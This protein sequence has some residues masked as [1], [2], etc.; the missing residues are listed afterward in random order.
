MAFAEAS[1]LGDCVTLLYPLTGMVN[2]AR[3]RWEGCILLCVSA[4]WVLLIPDAYSAPA[5]M[6]NAPS[7][8][9]FIEGGE[10][11]MGSQELTATTCP[12]L[13]GMRLVADAQP[14]HKVVISPFWIDETEV[15]NKAFGQFVQS[16]GYVTVAER[17]PSESELPGVPPEMRVPGG[18][19]FSPPKQGTVIDD[20]YQW[21]KF[22]KGADWR[23][24]EGPSSSLTGR[25][26]HPV[27]QVTYADAEAYAKW[28]GKRLPTEAEYEFAARGGLKGK[29]YPWGDTFQPDNRY[30]ANT[31]QGEFPFFDS[32]KDGF[33]GTA[34]V[35]S[36]PANGYGLF[37]LAGNVW[38]WCSDWYHPAYYIQL[39]KV[40][41]ARDPKGPESSLDPQELGVSKRV[42]RGGSYLCTDQYCSRYKVGTRGKGEPYSSTNHLGFRCVRSGDVR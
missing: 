19:V 13:E 35:R 17:G 2:Q 38:E 37:D 15:T 6:R 5:S 7:G 41:V 21:W 20:S 8:M 9:V 1:L 29:L 25:D 34:P 4:A 23:H 42:H 12:I 39:A 24:P 30:M 18:A 14:L 31:F 22:V 32:G 3:W 33:R 26:L 16:T 40:G 11:E 36:F 10:F 27:V 28:A